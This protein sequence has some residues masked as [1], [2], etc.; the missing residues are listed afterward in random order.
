MHVPTRVCTTVTLVRALAVAM[1]AGLAC[2]GEDQLSPDAGP[3]MNPHTTTA[4]TPP[5]PTSLTSSVSCTRR[6]NVST[7]SALSNATSNALA[8]DCII[9]AAGTYAVGVP[10][11]SRSG[12]ATQPITLEGA[13]PTTVFTLGGNG[14]IYVR[15]SYWRVRKLRVTNG[16]FGI[17]TERVKYVELDSLEVDNMQQQAINLR[18]GTNHTIVKN[19]KIHDTGKANPSWGEGVY[20]GGYAYY[21]SSSPDLAADDNQVLRTAFGPYVRAEAIDISEGADRVIANGN[22]IDGTGTVYKYGQ[23]NSLVGVRGTGHQFNDNV[24]SKGAPDGFMV[25]SGSATFHRNKIALYALT[26][27]PSPMGIYRNGSSTVIVGCD[28]IVTNIPA[29][30]AAY[31]VTCTP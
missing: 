19:S 6:V 18:Y 27:Y 9:V 5:P 10:S 23:M 31:N 14:G 22:T 28:N 11:W 20:I 12:T 25:Y 15:G 24:L 3:A 1:V 30:G 16:L 21:G 2:R 8:G 29:G 17:Q 13:G 4:P 7:V 26:N